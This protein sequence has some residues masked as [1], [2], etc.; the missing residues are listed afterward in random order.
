MSFL[1]FVWF[2]YLGPFRFIQNTQTE[3]ERERESCATAEKRSHLLLPASSSSLFPPC[4]LKQIGSQCADSTVLPPTLLA[5]KS[6]NA[7]RKKSTGRGT[8]DLLLWTRVCVVAPPFFHFSRGEQEAF[9]ER[10]VKV[11][12]MTECITFRIDE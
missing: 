5:A 6:N 3:R 4:Y 7:F 9:M 2:S 10:S 12:G 11:A 8:A 1:L